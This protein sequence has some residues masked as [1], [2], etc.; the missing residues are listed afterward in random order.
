MKTNLWKEQKGITLIALIVTIIVVLIIAGVGISVLSGE[1]GLLSKTQ[2]TK[3][4]Y[5]Q[6]EANELST[7]D[8]IEDF[9]SAQ[10]GK[11]IS[12]EKVTGE[13]ESLV[14]PILLNDCSNVYK[15]NVESAS[16]NGEIT[17]KVYGMENESG[18]MEYNAYS[19]ASAGDFYELREIHNAEQF[20]FDANNVPIKYTSTEGSEEGVLTYDKDVFGSEVTVTSFVEYK[21]KYTGFAYL[22]YKLASNEEITTD[23]LLSTVKYTLDQ[24]DLGYDYFIQMVG[25]TEEQGIEQEK[26]ERQLLPDILKN[27]KETVEAVKQC[28]IDQIGYNFYI[29][30]SSNDMEDDNPYKLLQE[31]IKKAN[32]YTLADFYAENQYLNEFKTRLTGNSII[33]CTILYLDE[34]LVDLNDNGKLANDDANAF[35]CAN[36]NN[37]AAY[38]K[39][40]GNA[41]I[42]RAFADYGAVTE[43]YK[44]NGGWKESLPTLQKIKLEDVF[45]DGVMEYSEFVSK[46]WV[47]LYNHYQMY[48]MD[49]FYKIMYDN[50]NDIDVNVAGLR[51]GYNAIFAP[52]YTD[53]LSTVFSRENS[54]T[55][56]IKEDTK[57]IEQQGVGD[58][59]DDLDDCITSINENIN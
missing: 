8:N 21:K 10:T 3:V 11:V 50:D 16:Y 33:P 2:S 12:S 4:T 17:L 38:F 44:G 31:L 39:T 27:K 46:Y 1:N 28:L 34:I 5:G 36:V 51:M 24:D 40:T 54:F 37:Y 48:G 43:D 42:Y 9:I 55:Y 49:N 52:Q 58:I 19:T 57:Y 14:L 53:M 6:A 23:D 35:S 59:I 30:G 15:L 18:V 20:G 25:G 13:N 7:L 41:G 29:L 47:E 56:D 22:T 32:P 26:K 45:N